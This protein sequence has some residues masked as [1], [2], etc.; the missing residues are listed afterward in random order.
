MGSTRRSF[1][2]EYRKQAV[3]LVLDGTS[4]AAAAK[5]I[6]VHEM[7]LRKWVKKESAD[8][9]ESGRTLDTNERAELV[10]VRKENAELQMQLE[11]A[12]K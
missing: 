2:A 3:Q 11:F 4:V 6:G 9:A 10:Q 12:K 1:T 8:G 7:T 5:N